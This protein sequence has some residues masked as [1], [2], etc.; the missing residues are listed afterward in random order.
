MANYSNPWQMLEK[1]WVVSMTL[2]VAV[3]SKAAHGC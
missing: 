3:S 1:F 2:H